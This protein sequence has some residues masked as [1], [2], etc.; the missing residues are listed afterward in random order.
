M[1]PGFSARGSVD[2]LPIRA[3][4]LTIIRIASQG[5]NETPDVEVRVP[6]PV[7]SGTAAIAFRERARTMILGRPFEF[8]K[9]WSAD[10]IAD[11]WR[12]GRMSFVGG[13]PGYFPYFF[14]A[15]W[16]IPF[17]WDRSSAYDQVTVVPVDRSGK[18][19]EYVDI[20][21][22]PATKEQFDR[23]NPKGYFE[24]AEG[25]HQVFFGAAVTAEMGPVAGA[26]YVSSNVDPKFVS[27]LQL[28][29]IR[30]EPISLEGI[31]MNPN[32]Q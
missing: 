25:R 10:E 4:G 24:W 13:F 8:G 9:F 18:P 15:A 3:G 14:N 2:F 28:S 32:K 29:V 16:T 31:A 26:G 30:S 21:G 27:K 17:G 19:I 20:M 1:T 11:G 12:F 22:E 23:E 6:A 5:G 7:P